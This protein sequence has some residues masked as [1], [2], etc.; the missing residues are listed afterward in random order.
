MIGPEVE[1]VCQLYACL[2]RSPVVVRVTR[3]C[4]GNLLSNM[5]CKHFLH[6]KFNATTLD[7]ESAAVALVACLQQRTSFHSCQSRFGRRIFPIPACCCRVHQFGSR[8]CCRSRRPIHFI[9]I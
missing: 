6:S 5:A 1:E 4:S 3:G 7:I 8:E 9:V 2:P